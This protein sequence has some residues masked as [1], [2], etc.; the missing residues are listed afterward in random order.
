MKTNEKNITWFNGF[1]CRND[2]ETLHG[3][4]ACVIWFTGLPASG[5]STIAHIVEKKLFDLGV[6][7][8]VFDGDNIRHG[9]CSDL[10][11]SVEDRSE[12]IRRIG[13]VS[14][15]LVDAGIVVL[16][17]LVSPFAAD[18]NRLREM[19]NQNE[20]IE[21]YINCSV[22][23]CASRDHKGNYK[24]AMAGEIKNFTGI[25]S[26]YEAPRN[27]EITINSAEESAENA[28]EKVVNY[29]TGAYFSKNMKS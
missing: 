8:Y 9:L 22:E 1:L 26:P 13:E 21:V 20:F 23:V 16:A 28:S 2:R 3:H 18:R 19:F 17:A 27:P 4:P 29:I 11:F 5:K 10:G 12:N 25:S 15:L 6:S 14:K 24:K 7:T